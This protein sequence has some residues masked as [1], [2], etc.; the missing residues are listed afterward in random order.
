MTDCRSCGRPWT[1]SLFQATSLVSA[2]LR[3]VSR[4]DVETISTIHRAQSVNKYCMGAPICKSLTEY[5]RKSV[6]PEYPRDT[7][8]YTRRC[9]QAMIYIETYNSMKTI[10]FRILAA[11]C[12]IVARYHSRCATSSLSSFCVG[13]VSPSSR[14]S[15]SVTGTVVQQT[16][17]D[18]LIRCRRRLL[19]IYI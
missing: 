11:R 5:A 8:K 2:S 14:D 10:E 6:T 16:L 17:Y 15:A 19:F 12:L 7:R 1:N 4:T 9:S 3:R 18:N 13:L